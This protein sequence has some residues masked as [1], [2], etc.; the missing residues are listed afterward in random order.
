MVQLVLGGFWLLEEALGF[1]RRGYVV[2][3]GTSLTAQAG[4]PIDDDVPYGQI[5]HLELTQGPAARLFGLK[6]L[7]L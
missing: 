6:H 5:Q 3:T 2:G 4:S 1:P 7:K